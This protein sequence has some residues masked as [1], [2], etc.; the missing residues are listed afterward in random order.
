MLLFSTLSNLAAEYFQ[1][2]SVY[3][4][5]YIDY[6]N[7]DSLREELSRYDMD[8]IVV[9]PVWKGTIFGPGKVLLA[10]DGIETL[11]LLRVSAHTIFLAV[12]PKEAFKA[13]LTTGCPL[14][15]MLVNPGPAWD[16]PKSMNE[17]V[18][19]VEDFEEE[20]GKRS[21][22]FAAIIYTWFPLSS[23]PT[24]LTLDTLYHLRNI[25]QLFSVVFVFLLI[26]YSCFTIQEAA[27]NIAVQIPIILTSI[28]A[29]LYGERKVETQA[30]KATEEPA[31]STYSVAFC[32]PRPRAPPRAGGDYDV[33]LA[34]AIPPPAIHAPVGLAP[35]AY[36][37]FDPDY[38]I[39]PPEEQAIG[40]R[41]S[42]FVEVQ[43]FVL[44]GFK[45]LLRGLRIA[46]DVH[47]DGEWHQGIERVVLHQEAKRANE[48]KPDLLR[49][50]GCWLPPR[51]YALK[52]IEILTTPLAPNDGYHRIQ[53]DGVN[54][55]HLNIVQN[56]HHSSDEMMFHVKIMLRQGLVLCIVAVYLIFK[57]GV[58]I[59]A[60]RKS[61]N[62]VAETALKITL[63]VFAGLGAIYGVLAGRVR[64]I[65]TPFT[66]W[67]LCEVST[68]M[69]L[70][71][72]KYE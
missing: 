20:H 71:T 68:G 13:V 59:Y 49:R 39:I 55:P 54:H 46:Y 43:P 26:R 23:H 1:A 53:I 25:D 27:A 52:S 8:G 58:G 57:E 63:A 66:I 41:L 11:D 35:A 21:A 28:T 37:I 65:S 7:P 42:I 12:Y 24:H 29:F 47:A 34:P 17:F 36:G 60:S 51:A 10:D 30:K 50:V 18:D 22:H 48:I 4:T 9:M 5:F 70:E 72:F 40:E 15:K 67:L 38:L 32:C 14:L 19:M 16:K 31:T 61:L 62:E 64:S 56:C 69:E 6:R 33:A 45:T 44:P 3:D 2:T